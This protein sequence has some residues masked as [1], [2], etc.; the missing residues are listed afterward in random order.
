MFLN[1]KEDMWRLDSIEGGLLCFLV[2]FFGIKVSY[3]GTCC[4][5]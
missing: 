3:S 2:F 1:L 5:E 4:L